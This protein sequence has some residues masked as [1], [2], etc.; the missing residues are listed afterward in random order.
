MKTLDEMIE[1]MRV[2]AK[3]AN[4]SGFSFCVAIAPPIPEP[5][6][7]LSCGESLKILGLADVIKSNVHMQNKF[8]RVN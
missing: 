8:T 1:A 3:E 7:T 2:M 5:V 6:T 4:E